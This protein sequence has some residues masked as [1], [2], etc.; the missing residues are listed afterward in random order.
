MMELFN[1]SERPFYRFGDMILLE[2]IG[3]SEWIS[4]IMKSFNDSGKTINEVFAESIVGQM[5][6]HPYYIQMYCDYVWSLTTKA[7]SDDILNFAI[8]EMINH[9]AFMF[10]ADLE[11]L[12][13]TQINLIKAIAAGETQLTSKHTGDKYRLGTL[14][15]VLKNKELLRSRDILDAQGAQLSFLDPVFE[16]WLKRMF[17]I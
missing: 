4:F 5:R 17:I 13:G 12:S 3:T 16:I 1:Q 7:V 6:N 14:R 15:N 8:E 10:Q 2:K 11:N 9:S